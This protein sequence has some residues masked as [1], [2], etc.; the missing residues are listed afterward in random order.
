MQVP[1]AQI[2]SPFSRVVP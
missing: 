2:G 1:H